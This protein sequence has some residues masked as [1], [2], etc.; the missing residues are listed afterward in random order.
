MNEIIKRRVKELNELATCIKV[1][2]KCLLEDI[3]EI[4]TSEDL[5]IVENKFELIKDYAQQGYDKVMI[6][7][8]EFEEG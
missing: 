2:A 6:T 3:D 1:E 5:A 4:E 7:Y 8:D